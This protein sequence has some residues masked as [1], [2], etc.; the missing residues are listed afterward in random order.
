MD[1]FCLYQDTEAVGQNW[2]V[3]APLSAWLCH[4]NGVIFCVCYAMAKAKKPALQVGSAKSFNSKRRSMLN[5]F[6]SKY[7]EAEGV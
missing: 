6:R 3:R 5:Y 2:A 4:T 1:K 7:T